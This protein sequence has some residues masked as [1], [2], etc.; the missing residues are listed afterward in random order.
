MAHRE[1][2]HHIQQ[3]MKWNTAQH[4]VKIN[5]MV[6]IKDDRLPPTRW[7]LGRI[8]GVTPGNDGLVRVV[9]IRTK[10]GELDRPITKICLLPSQ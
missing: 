4:N 7:L 8:V 9:K 10:N 6:I 1:Y 5:D 3:S 2:L